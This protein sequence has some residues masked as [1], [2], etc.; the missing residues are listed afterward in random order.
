MR[1]FILQWDVA[2]TRCPPHSYHNTLWSSED[3]LSVAICQTQPTINTTCTRKGIEAPIVP[4]AHLDGA[5]QCLGRRVAMD[6]KL[7][8]PSSVAG[9]EQG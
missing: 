4:V 7:V 9:F 3:A 1:P 6:P 2:S 5:L 8:D